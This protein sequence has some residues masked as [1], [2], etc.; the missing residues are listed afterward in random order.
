MAVSQGYHVRVT[1]ENQVNFRFLQVLEG[2]DDW[3]LWIFVIP[4]FS[5]F[6][7]SKNPFFSFSKPAFL[8]DFRNPGQLTVSQVLEG[9]DLCDSTPNYM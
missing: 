3:V 5:T 1:S 7:R 4:S 8:E 9:T 6:S 2:T